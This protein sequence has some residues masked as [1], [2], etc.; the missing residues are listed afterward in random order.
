MSY[1]NPPQDY[2]SSPDRW[3]PAGGQPPAYPQQQQPPY[4]GQ[5]PYGGAQPGWAPEPRPLPTGPGWGPP[6]QQQ[7]LPT[8]TGEGWQPTH[9][10]AHGESRYQPP[11]VQR[12]GSG[13]KWALV[14]VAVAVVGVL[15]Y[16]FWPSSGSGFDVKV[17]KCQSTGSVATVGL[18]VHNKGSDTQTATIRVEYHDKAGKIVDSDTVL[19]HDV[20]A[21]DTQPVEQ[22]TIL[23]AD[24]GAVT[25][26]V[27][28]VA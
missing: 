5:A 21:G 27:T 18:S 4:G 16:F 13:G 6:A 19:A 22:S 8:G 17:T 1:A 25:C 24:G 12:S 14:V 26:H 10:T 2:P 11:P 7:A 20:G 23:D 15:A 28:A 3:P 9:H